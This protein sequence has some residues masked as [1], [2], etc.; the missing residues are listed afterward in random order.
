VTHTASNTIGASSLHRISFQNIDTSNW[1]KWLS[2]FEQ[3]AEFLPSQIAQTA[4]FSVS[5]GWYCEPSHFRVTSP[6]KTSY[7]MPSYFSIKPNII[8]L[9]LDPNELFMKFLSYIV[10]VKSIFC[11]SDGKNL[12]PIDIT[13]YIY[14]K[15]A[16]TS[17]KNT[18]NKVKNGFETFAK[19]YN[20]VLEE[21]EYSKLGI[22]F[23]KKSYFAYHAL[24]TSSN[25]I[26]NLLNNM[27]YNEKIDL[28][29]TFEWC[30]I[31]P[32]LLALWNDDSGVVKSLLDSGANPDFA[33]CNGA[34]PLYIASVTGLKDIVKLLLEHKADPNLAKNGGITPIVAS[35]CM[36]KLSTA[37]AILENAFDRIDHKYNKLKIQEHCPEMLNEYE[38]LVA[39]VQAQH[40]EL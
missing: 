6:H 25:I 28:Q 14:L 39:A 36:N 7:K 1:I 26:E 31:N 8:S 30:N 5:N 2:P 19:Q 12:E 37:Q 23:F 4:T 9:L 29:D 20:V 17:P 11:N 33:R 40:N 38:N 27:T 13:E 10:D 15:D 3:F 32:L 21:F 22:S 34:T 16:I 24:T 18:L 35:T